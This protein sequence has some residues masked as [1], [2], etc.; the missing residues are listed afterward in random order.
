MTQLERRNIRTSDREYDSGGEK[1]AIEYQE[2]PKDSILPEVFA[3]GYFLDKSK[4]W[5]WDEI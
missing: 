5:V 3:G 1:H 4:A 2:I